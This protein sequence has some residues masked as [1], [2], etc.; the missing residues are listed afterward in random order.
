MTEV[1]Q[2]IPPGAGVVGGEDVEDDP[3]GADE[4][5]PAAVDWLALDSEALL[6]GPAVPVAAGVRADLSS[7]S[8]CCLAVRRARRAVAATS[9]ASR[10]SAAA[11]VVVTTVCRG[12]KTAALAATRASATA[13]P[14]SAP[15]RRWSLVVRR[16]LSAP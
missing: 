2:A 5:V 6:D 12:R 8:A 14:R 10:R 11:V 3:S 9:S 13:R 4:E 7:R 16:A 15:A 1:P